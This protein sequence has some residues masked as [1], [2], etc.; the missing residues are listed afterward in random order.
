MS[1]LFGST[2]NLPAPEQKPLGLDS[3]RIST[4]EAARP[5]PVILGRARVGVTWLSQPFS[6]RLDEVKREMGK[7]D[8][9]TG[10]NVFANI[11]GLIGHGPVDL[12]ESIW[13][14]QEKVWPLDESAGISRGAEDYV[15][16]TIENYGDWTFYWGTETQDF[17]PLLTTLSEDTDRNPDG[18]IAPNVAEE[19]PAY[20]GQCYFVANQQFMGF[21]AQSVQNVEVVVGRYP[22]IGSMSPDSNLQNDCTLAAAI[23]DG[24][25]NE[26]YG[27]GLELSRLD[28]AAITAFDAQLIAEELA[29]SPIINRISP[30]SGFLT[31]TLENVDGYHTIKG[32]GTFSLGLVRGVPCND[33]DLPRF[34][35]TCMLEPPQPSI[36][37]F[38]ETKNEVRVKFTNGENDFNEDATPGDSTGAF[39][40]SGEYAL[41]FLDRPWITRPKMASRVAMVSAKVLGQV[42]QTGTIRIRKSKLQDLEAGDGFYL[43][44]AHYGMCWL[45]CRAITLRFA[46]YKSEVEIDYQVDRGYLAEETYTPVAYV[47]PGR[48]EPIITPF[49]QATVIELPYE[50]KG[51]E[52]PLLAFLAARP[53][54]MTSQFRVHQ[55]VGATHST[56]HLVESFARYGTLDADYSATDTGTISVTLTG[57]DV[58]M[59][60]EISESEA[61]ADKWLA[62]IGDEIM[63]FWDVDPA[64]TNQYTAQVKR[65]RF[66]TKR[67]DHSAGAAVWIIS[68]DA[69]RASKFTADKQPHGAGAIQTFRLASIVLGSELAFA[70]ATEVNVT[71]TD[72]SKRPWKPINLAAPGTWNGSAS[73]AMT[74][75]IHNRETGAFKA[76]AEGPVNYIEIRRLAGDTDE[77]PAVSPRALVKLEASTTGYTLTGAELVA[78]LG[79]AQSFVARL[80]MKGKGLESRHYDE[81]TIVKV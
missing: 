70:D 66:D 10:Y 40:S 3:K 75:S 38:G 63:S 47:R 67:L 79:S 77:Y 45:H 34:D 33:P 62:L 24:L 72:R 55:V 74:W 28:Q 65:E 16:I 71:F 35:E 9:V 44:Y 7:E 53:N 18:V 8:V 14:N 76:D 64:G 36:A 1:F 31:R 58:A 43:N 27:L 73:V 30:F 37:A 51:G 41:E 48:I 50:P 17:D 56:V 12:I 13:F 20:V 52:A 68:R 29:I 25:M 32:D 81:A 42:A 46:A 2:K 59:A 57:V 49:A 6:L 61:E 21:N 78:A 4:N 80:Y 19:H 11:A 54:A 26:R 39:A 5:V 60:L 23:V 69:I 15:T 22:S